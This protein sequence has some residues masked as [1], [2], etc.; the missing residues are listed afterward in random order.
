MFHSGVGLESGPLQ[1]EV[2][3]L[4]I[5]SWQGNAFHQISG[6][7]CRCHDVE[8]V[9]A[10]NIVDRVINPNFNTTILQFSHGEMIPKTI[11]NMGSISLYLADIQLAT[12][13]TCNNVG[14]HESTKS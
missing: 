7:R 9:L 11:F 4:T 13:P 8:H 1:L 14:R 2:L 6:S 5:N 3:G 12:N 10:R